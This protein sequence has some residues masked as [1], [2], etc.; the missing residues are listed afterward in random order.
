MISDPAHRYRE[1]PNVDQ[2]R[3]HHHQR[4]RTGPPHRPCIGSRTDCSLHQHP[5]QHYINVLVG[6]GNSAR[7]GN[8]FDRQNPFGPGGYRGQTGDRAARGRNALRPSARRQRRQF[9]V[10]RLDRQRNHIDA[11]KVHV[12]TAPLPASPKRPVKTNFLRYVLSNTRI[13]EFN[14]MGY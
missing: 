9:R 7:P 4:L 8:G 3:L 1:T 12:W 10:Y 14:L 6:R 2:P 5:G 13:L 11:G